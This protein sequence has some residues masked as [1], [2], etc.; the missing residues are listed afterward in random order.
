MMLTEGYDCPPIDALVLCRP[1]KNESLIIQMIGRALRKSENKTDALI[2]D[3]VFR[4]EQEDI[5]SITASG[6]FGK[7]AELHLKSPDLSFAQLQ[8]LQAERAPHLYSIVN[9]IDQL[10]H[11]KMVEEESIR[12]QEAKEKEEQDDF[13]YNLFEMTQNVEINPET[14]VY[15]TLFDSRT[16][17]ELLT[18][19]PKL[20][21]PTFWKQLDLNYKQVFNKHAYIK[22]DQITNKQIYKLVNEYKLEEDK[23]KGLSKLQAWALIETI[24]NE[25][26]IDQK[27]KDNLRGLGIND[28]LMPSNNGE[29]K[30]LIEDMKTRK[31]KNLQQH[32]TDQ[33][34]KTKH[35]KMIEK[36][37]KKNSNDR[38]IVDIREA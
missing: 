9:L 15:K 11:K 1:T 21:L 14:F 18:L 28:H 23:V 3:L 38:H 17:R 29:G 27:Q 30:A 35:F 34:T 33:F 13:Q 16:H 19:I 7:Y 37:E 12:S 22:Y 5:I 8:K 32:W 31:A 10:K 4:R 20:D 2:I 25:Q 36:R 6:L 26:P 24:V